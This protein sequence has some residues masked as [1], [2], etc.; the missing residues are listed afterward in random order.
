MIRCAEFIE[1]NGFD[2]GEDPMKVLIIDDEEDSLYL[3]ASFFESEG[4]E[5]QEASTSREGLKM[6]QQSEPDL[7]IL[8]VRLPH[9]S[10]REVCQLIRTF[11]DVPIVMVSA[12]DRSNEDIIR[13]LNVGADDYLPKP[14]DF[15]LLK[16]RV[17]S[18]LRRSTRT[19]WRESR[20]AYIDPFL[21]VDLYRQQVQ[22]EGQPV[23]LSP[24]EYRLLALLVRNANQTVP[25]LEI[26]ETLWPRADPD[27][28]TGYVH[29][30]VKRLRKI[31]EPDQQNPRY[32]ITD[33][34]L[35]YHF[36]SQH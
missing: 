26:V 23:S 1:Y 14:I 24:L 9:L 6:L 13:G 10:G 28:Y 2:T 11:S 20:P 29:T 32:I 8:D 34:G 16:A 7:V 15:D 18:L 3:L 36:E 12:Y 31:I 21:I 33:H 5:V 17:T 19:T 4:Y 27:E 25:S 30:Y 35:G 22:I